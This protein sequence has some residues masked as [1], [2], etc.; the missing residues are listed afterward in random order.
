VA[1]VWHDQANVAIDVEDAIT[2]DLEENANF[3]FSAPGFMG[4]KSLYDVNS[5]ADF[6]SWL[7]L[8]LIPLVLGHNKSVPED[9]L[10][11]VPEPKGL[12]SRAFYLNFNKI[13]GGVLLRQARASEQPLP[14]PA[15]RAFYGQS[16]WSD[17]SFPVD[18][19][20]RPLINDVLI[21][22]PSYS[23]DLNRWLLLADS[24]TQMDTTLTD[25][26]SSNWL[27]AMTMEANANFI[28][29][30]AHFSTLT[31]TDIHFFQSRSGHMWRS[32][33]HE[34][35]HMLPF[36]FGYKRVLRITVDAIFVLQLTWI[37]TVELREMCAAFSINRNLGKSPLSF[38]REYTDVWNIVD[39]S[40]VALGGAIVAMYG[41]VVSQ[42]SDLRDALISL[43]ANGKLND[44]A[45]LLFFFEDFKDTSSSYHWMRYLC[46]FYPLVI[47]MRL[48]KA[49]SAQ[50]RLALV[51]RTLSA[52]SVDL[53]HF[54]IVFCAIFFAYA[55]AGNVL[56]GREVDEFSHLERSI[57]TCFSILMG[58][59]NIAA[60][61]QTGRWLMTLWFTTFM[62]L[63]LLTVLNMLLAIIMDCY[64][65]VK[66]QI[67]SSETLCEQAFELFRR[68]R[69]NMRR[70][71]VSLYHIS[72][73]YAVQF[74]APIADIL[75]MENS[76]EAII[77]TDEFC[78]QVSGLKPVQA[79]RLLLMSLQC[80][81]VNLE[82]MNPLSLS[83][84]MI[85]IG[86]IHQK[87]TLYVDRQDGIEDEKREEHSR[88]KA[89][90][91][92]GP[93]QA[94]EKL[95]CKS[96]KGVPLG[97]AFK[98]T[99]E[100]AISFPLGKLPSPGGGIVYTKGSQALASQFELETLLLAAHA[101][102]T[103]RGGAQERPGLKVLQSLLGTAIEALSW[104]EVHV[105]LVDDP[106]ME[107][108]GNELRAS[109][110]GVRPS[111]ACWCVSSDVPDKAFNEV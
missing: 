72:H 31:Y 107:H 83:K 96:G 48:F 11:Y 57:L 103:K 49:F 27:S 8:G 17:D 32:V 100:H 44:R 108:S 38:F 55:L 39:W 15:L 37:L 26:E 95:D 54:L 45:S 76:C 58:D 2:F 7:R 82:T 69:Q 89:S 80:Y 97:T 111:P 43:N 9:V 30:N 35:L 59:F 24:E 109:A 60:M 71:R 25:L 87:L 21:A 19:H 84:A 65:R 105:P 51:T 98:A 12:K 101:R 77:S 79:H 102:L 23:A 110:N 42:T 53:C 62:G 75:R 41:L 36:G 56:F 63:V 20:Q 47:M 18:M 70:E 88:R 93:P 34:T 52:A 67:S 3:A 92:A 4:H 14:D 5:Y 68:W 33:T 16:V 61:D 6:H 50:P 46:F 86:K 22:R 66:G 1:F 73:C 104:E 40:T 29:Y 106:V 94:E 91:D 10:D 99:H 78:R 64:T 90:G 85:V 13:V 74:G 81:V 28:V